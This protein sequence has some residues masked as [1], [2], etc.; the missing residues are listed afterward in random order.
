M[1]T[2]LNPFAQVLEA[3]RSLK[4]TRGFYT[5]RKQSTASK[6]FFALILGAIYCFLFY[7]LLALRINT[8]KELNAFLNSLPEFSY[9]NGELYCEERYEL[10]YEGQ[11]IV[12]D[13]DK[14]AWNIE[15]AS[16]VQD[17]SGDVSTQ[18]FH[19]GDT[20]NINT[21]IQKGME[22]STISEIYLVSSTN[23][24]IFYPDDFKYAE[25]KLS[26]IGNMYNLQ[27]FSKLQLLSDYKGFITTVAILL[28]L[29]SMI[30]IFP[31]L[32]LE[33]LF[34]ALVGLII[35][36]IC[37]SKEKFSTI[38][39]ISFYV[40]DVLYFFQY[41][42]IG[43]NYFWG[44]VLGNT[45]VLILYIIMMVRILKKGDYV[46]KPASSY[47]NSLND[48]ID[49]FLKADTVPP[50]IPPR[51]EPSNP[52]PTYHS[53]DTNPYSETENRSNS[54]T[55]PVSSPFSLNT[56]ET[57]FEKEKPEEPAAPSSSGFSLKLKE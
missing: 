16:L 57:T 33:T 36:A 32:L 35:N 43:L 45:I 12:V 27:S 31:S 22:D 38:F 15:Q 56:E 14:Q 13:T 10:Q 42:F 44:C 52:A 2:K 48:D 17:R 29:F 20:S 46:A 37:K 49:A 53:M 47:N 8:N 1:F 50:T 11:Y 25:V 4:D 34:F 6:F 26:E 19:D 39:W 54:D 28:S 51:Q 24:V 7:G 9:T 3:F 41:I 40:L 18:N 21:Y 55:P 5:L 23:I 30:F